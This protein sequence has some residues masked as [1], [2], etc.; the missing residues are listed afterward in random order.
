MTPFRRASPILAVLG[1][2]VS[3]AVASAKDALTPAEIE[4]GEAQLK[5]MLKD[6]PAMAPYT[7]MGDPLW[8]WASRQFAGEHVDGGIEWDAAEIVPAWEAAYYAPTSDRRAFIRVS[9]R[10]VS[11]ERKSLAMTGSVLWVNAA[12]E[13]INARSHARSSRLNERAQC[14]QVSR[15]AYIVGTALIE[16]ES[17]RAFKAF[18][19]ETWV[20]HCRRLARPADDPAWFNG[21]FPLMGHPEDTAAWALD[22][23]NGHGAYLGATYD[24]LVGAGVTP[25]VFGGVVYVGDDE[26][27]QVDGI[28]AELVTHIPA[29]RGG[30]TSAYYGLVGIAIE[31]AGGH[32]RELQLGYIGATGDQTFPPVFYLMTYDSTGEPVVTYLSSTSAGTPDSAGAEGAR[33]RYELTLDEAGVVT[34]RIDGRDYV[35]GTSERKVEAAFSKGRGQAAF[36]VDRSGLTVAAEIKALRYRLGNAWRDVSPEHTRRLLGRGIGIRSEESAFMVEGLTAGC[37][38]PSPSAPAAP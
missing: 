27:V 25:T 30:T 1:I 36:R 13:L 2:L 7:K 6:R 31:S 22:E 17:M 16:S 26:S 35:G 38:A 32:R 12:F 21:R 20:P 18:Y 9:P 24:R 19:D 37:E 28:A 11:A 3:V 34:A 5:Q 8:R 10:F 15:P 33:H 14:G 4:W 29:D 23:R